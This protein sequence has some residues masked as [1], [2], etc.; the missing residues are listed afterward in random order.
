MALNTPPLPSFSSPPSTTQTSL[1]YTCN[2]DQVEPDCADDD[3]GV[4]LGGQFTAE[5]VAWAQNQ[6][7][8]FLADLDAKAKEWK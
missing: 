4:H 1:N 8:K 6:C 7:V 5:Q 2:V 3:E